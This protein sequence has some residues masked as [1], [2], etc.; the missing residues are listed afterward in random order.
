[1]SVRD[2]QRLENQEKVPDRSWLSKT[3]GRLSR[4]I[5]ETV[6][7]WLLKLVDTTGERLTL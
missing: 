4:E 2:F 1:M 3:P 7:N 6:F 5:D